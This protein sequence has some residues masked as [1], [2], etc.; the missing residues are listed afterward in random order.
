MAGV[1]RH[2]C[3]LGL[4]L[5][6]QLLKIKLFFFSKWPLRPVFS[7]EVPKLPFWVHKI[8]P[9]CAAQQKDAARY[10]LLVYC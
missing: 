5:L 1:S 10:F 3:I 9:F 7:Q 6:T 4:P 8:S 2:H